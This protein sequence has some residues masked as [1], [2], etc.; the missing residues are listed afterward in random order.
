MWCMDSLGKGLNTK[1]AGIRGLIEAHDRH[2]AFCLELNGVPQRH[3]IHNS[4]AAFYWWVY[5]NNGRRAHERS[6]ACD[7]SGWG[8]IF[9]QCLFPFCYFSVP[10]GL[11]LH[12]I[13]LS[14]TA[15][16]LQIVCTNIFKYVLRNLKIYY[17]YYYY[18][19]LY[20]ISIAS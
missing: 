1:F 3:L 17:Y 9:L 10:L 14:T 8:R 11:L 16:V 13:S 19:I 6:H 18:Y 2:W 12:M 7:L 4:K 20:L 5:H 15:N